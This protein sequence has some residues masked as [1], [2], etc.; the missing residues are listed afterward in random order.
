MQAEEAKPAVPGKTFTW[1]GKQSACSAEAAVFAEQFRPYG[2]RRRPESE[3]TAAYLSFSTCSAQPRDSKPQP[4][5]NKPLNGSGPPKLPRPCERDVAEEL[6]QT[7]RS[8]H[9]THAR[10]QAPIFH[11]WRSHFGE[12][13]YPHVC[14][15]VLRFTQEI[16]M[17]RQHRYK[18][19]T[20]DQRRRNTR[21]DEFAI[22]KLPACICKLQY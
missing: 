1:E 5:Q 15:L 9:G 4:S 13:K 3:R 6:R 8:Q 20:K 2:Y 10:C 7:S 14:A 16:L 19:K 17:E 22:R 11:R 18:T 21:E 12:L